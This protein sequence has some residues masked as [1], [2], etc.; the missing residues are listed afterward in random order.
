MS[1]DRRVG[2]GRRMKLPAISNAKTQEQLSSVLPRAMTHETF[3][4]F[5]DYV[6]GHLGIKGSKEQ[7]YEFF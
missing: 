7:G 1:G 5:R 6:T 4:R 3:C 2:P